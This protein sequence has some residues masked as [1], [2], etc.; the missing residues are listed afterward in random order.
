MITNGRLLLVAGV[1]LAVIVIVFL[2]SR[3]TSE[4]FANIN[5]ITNIGSLDSM[6]YKRV[7]APESTVDAPNFADLADSGDQLHQLSQLQGSELLPR[8]STPH[9]IDVADPAV[10]H[11]MA[12]GPRVASMLKSRFKD[13]SLAGFIRGDI[14]LKYQPDV[15]L[16]EKTHH[17]RDDLRMDGMFSPHFQSLY[18][19]Y[20]HG[21]KNMPAMVAGVGAGGKSGVI[22]DS[23]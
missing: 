4:S 16:I 14:P 19:Q 2:C 11:Y 23:Y 9:N 8:I 6:K 7:Q 13:Y 22:M 15:C 18:D 21:Y 17:T 20:T 3:K 12:N 1:I 5:G 10:H